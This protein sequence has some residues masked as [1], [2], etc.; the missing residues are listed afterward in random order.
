MY[1][2]ARSLGAAA[3]FAIDPLLWV[4]AAAAFI[5]SVA[6]HRWW[7]PFLMFPLAVILYR[8]SADFIVSQQLIHRGIPGEPLGMTQDKWVACLLLGVGLATIVQMTRW[9]FRLIARP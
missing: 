4:F 8:V 7:I 6:L 2:L 1:I 5:L 9:A 3:A